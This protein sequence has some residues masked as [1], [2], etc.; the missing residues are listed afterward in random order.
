MWLQSAL[1]GQRA[2]VGHKKLKRSLMIHVKLKLFSRIFVAIL[3]QV[4]AMLA[5]M[6][7]IFLVVQ[8]AYADEVTRRAHRR[9]EEA[10]ESTDSQLDSEFTFYRARAQRQGRSS[11][12]SGHSCLFAPGGGKS[13]WKGAASRGAALYQKRKTFLIYRARQAVVLR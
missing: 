11:T 3:A 5:S 4:L 2:S 6:I 7:L 9:V 1:R 13:Y 8:Q 12:R 10:R